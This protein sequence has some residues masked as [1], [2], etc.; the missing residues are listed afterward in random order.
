MKKNLLTLVGILWFFLGCRSLP[1]GEILTPQESAAIRA[2]SEVFAAVVHPQVEPGAKVQLFRQDSLR[3]DPQPYGHP[4]GFR[5][6]AG[7]SQGYD[8]GGLFDL[9]DSATMRRITR[10]R[11]A[12]LK[13]YGAVE[14]KVISYPMCGGT[15]AP[16]PPPPRDGSV[17]PADTSRARSG[18][19]A[20]SESY[21]TVGIPVP[22]EPTS[23]R[24]FNERSG[25][26]ANPAGELWTT[27]VND[28]YAGPGGQNWMQYAWVF[29]RNPST[30]Q[31]VLVASILVAWAE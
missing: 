29:R 20:V 14:G 6:T 22:G 26:D 7:G 23:L 8:P 5:E 30:R 3:F 16:P 19:P 25:L 2:D 12:I 4:Q 11:S 24:R 1:Q 13:A 21:R 9:P 18:C 17:R 10:S 28:Y 31:L 15:L 27:I